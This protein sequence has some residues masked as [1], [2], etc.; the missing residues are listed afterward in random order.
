MP[1]FD[2]VARIALLVLAVL[3]AASITTAVLRYSRPGRDFSELTA[4]VRA[5][6][7]MAALFFASIAV[8]RILSLVFLALV[9]LWAMKEYVSLLE[10]RPADR[11]ALVL[12]FLAIP[13][14]YY[15]VAAGWYGMFVVFIPVY[16]FLLLPLR[17]V[18]QG[19]TAGFLAS[20]SQMQWG[21]MA[22]GFGLSHLGLLL[23]FPGIP[24]L[25]VDG[26]TLLLFL[27][28]V[29]EGSD[30]LQYIWGKTLGRHPI[31]PRVSPNKTWEGFLLG[32]VTTMAASLLLRFL[33][34]F[35]VAE[36]LLVSCLVTVAGFFGGAVLSAVKR[37]FGV[38]DFG[39][40]IPGHGGV[41]DRVDS[42]CYAAP[43]FLHYVRYFHPEVA[44]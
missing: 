9:G 14:Q 30:V 1:S 7:V 39:R 12:A 27:V 13:V 43:V 40:L 26:R 11:R 23:T 15:W 42:L 16:M 17:L 33:T 3:L 41:L 10:T 19:D 22:F 36:T 20:A 6:W 32:V 25:Q 35:S 2:P 5:W 44:F 18:L 37:D 24:D 34:P 29:V 21:L 28:F 4:R 8:T 31:L 38:K